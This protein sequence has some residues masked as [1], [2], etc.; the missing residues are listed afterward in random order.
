M[1]FIGMLN[2]Y[3]NQNNSFLGMWAA[4]SRVL[5]QKKIIRFYCIFNWDWEGLHI[6][7]RS[8]GFGFVS[9]EKKDPEYTVNENRTLITLSSFFNVHIR[10]RNPG[11]M[12]ECGLLKWLFYAGLTYLI[13]IFFRLDKLAQNR[14]SKR[15]LIYLDV[16]IICRL[17]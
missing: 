17:F 12:S 14:V 1:T 2:L 5:F 7:W 11:V 9:R 4:D 13:F 3:V 10:S 16:R 8:L 15:E 6:G